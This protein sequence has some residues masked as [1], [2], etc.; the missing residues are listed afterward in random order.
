VRW[1]LVDL[2]QLA[3]F[4]NCNFW[5]Q[6][7]LCD[8]AECLYVT[9]QSEFLVDTDAGVDDILALFVLM[10]IRSPSAIDVAVTFGN[11]TL[12]QAMSNV[13][14]LS[15]VSGLDPRKM[16]RGCS[17]PLSGEPHFA[18]NVHGADGLGG[19][20]S[21]YP[22]RPPPI[23][24][25]RDLFAHTQLGPHHKIVA[26]GPMTD[27]ARLS[28]GGS[29]VSHRLF[30]MGGAFDVKGNIT[31]FAEFN[32]YSDPEA[33]NYVFE[34]YA[35]EIFV[36]PLDVCNTIILGREYLRDICARN[37]APTLTFLNLIHQHYMDF[38]RKT[39]GINGCHPHDALTVCAAVNADLFTWTRGWARVLL[40]GPERGRSLFGP[41]PTGRHHLA[42]SVDAPR[43]F[44]ILEWA[45]TSFK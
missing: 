12:E 8:A 35:G 21:S 39:E 18:T 40:D 27:I 31:P 37:P 24:S 41:D 6:N 22:W 4:A 13:G 30:V 11:V 36:I 45:V 26:L 42:R 34:H 44:E 15:F 7:V 14:L 9:K 43:F 16:L 25:F 38:Y 32:F 23:C 5:H 28:H 17:G 10:Q 3:C 29:R 2:D 19:I 33:A 1:R 20:T